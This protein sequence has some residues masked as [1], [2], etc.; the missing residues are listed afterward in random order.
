[1]LKQNK[2]YGN[3]FLFQQ[4]EK[5]KKNLYFLKKLYLKIIKVFTIY[6]SVDFFSNFMN[7]KNQISLLNRYFFF[8]NIFFF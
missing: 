2:I 4:C 8:L 1:M 6:Y 5:L 3:F 7:L